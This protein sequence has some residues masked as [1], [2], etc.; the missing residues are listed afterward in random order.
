M[1]D[2]EQDNSVGRLRLGLA[3]QRGAVAISVL[4]VSQVSLAQ[5][6]PVP[7]VAQLRP[8]AG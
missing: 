5:P 6:V 2:S 8:D 3:L 4:V 1:C 7:Q